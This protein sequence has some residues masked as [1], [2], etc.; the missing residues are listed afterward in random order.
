MRFGSFFLWAIVHYDS[1]IGDITETILG[2][3][4]IVDK[5]D[6][7]GTL[8]SIDYALSQWDKFV[9]KRSGP[10]NLVIGAFDQVPILH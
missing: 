9:G 5:V 10:W 3:K 7:V 4:G 6:G 2:D 1:S 8:N